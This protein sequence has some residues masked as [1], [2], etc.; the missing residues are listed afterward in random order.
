MSDPR[1]GDHAVGLELQL[2][3]LVVRLE[4]ARRRGWADD[5]HALELEVTALQLELADAAEQATD[6][7]YRPILV[8]GA[9]TAED[10]AHRPRT[11]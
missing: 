8:R 10:L 2:E 3:E 9:E 4:Q 7:H 6:R 5:V 11:A 1:L